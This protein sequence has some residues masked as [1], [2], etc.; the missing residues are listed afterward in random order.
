[1]LALP[2]NPAAMRVAAQSDPRIYPH[3]FRKTH[4]S[5]KRTA[6]VGLR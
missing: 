5:L 1:M 4:Y 2:E 3:E 6:D